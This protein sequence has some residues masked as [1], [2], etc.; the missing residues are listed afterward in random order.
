V[1]NISIAE[2]TVTDSG[3]LLVVPE[4]PTGD[5]FAFVYRAAMEINWAA[6]SRGLISPAPRPGGWSHADWFRQTVAAV[7]DEYRARL[8]I[9]PRTKW[10]VTDDLRHEIEA[11]YDEASGKA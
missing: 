7:V 2:I 1:R 8:V 5:D 11:S 9:G 4:L 10:N 6:N 3:R